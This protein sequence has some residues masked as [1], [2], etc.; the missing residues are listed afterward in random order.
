MQTENII[1]PE[2][3]SPSKSKTSAC[4]NPDITL[5]ELHDFSPNTTHTIRVHME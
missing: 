4:K 2:P 3:Q 1:R 5:I